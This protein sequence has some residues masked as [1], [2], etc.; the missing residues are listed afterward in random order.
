MGDMLST[1]AWVSPYNR[2]PS[3]KSPLLDVEISLSVSP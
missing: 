3:P 1:W 2:Q